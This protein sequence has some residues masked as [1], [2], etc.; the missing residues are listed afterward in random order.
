MF[1]SVIICTRN[2]CDKLANVL[3]SL[4][5]VNVPDGLLW[6]VLIVDN[7]STDS[8]VEVCKPFI[9][10][11]SGNYRYVFEGRKGKSVA[12]NRGITHARGDI[13]AFTDDDCIVARTWLAELAN[14]YA[15][16]PELAV[17]GGRV[18]LYNERDKPKSILTFG[19]RIDLS[20]N[21][22]RVFGPAIMGANMSF[23]KEVFN[24]VGEFD[25]LLGPGSKSGAIAEDLDYIYMAYRNGFKVVYFPNIVVYHDHGRQTD[26]E[27]D[28]LSY[29]Y[30][31][32]RG[33]FYC[34]HV[35]N[36]IE[37]VRRLYWD[38]RRHVEDFVSNF[39]AGQSTRN[40]R[41]AL[42]ALAVGAISRLGG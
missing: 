15:S 32:G 4:D 20:T 29:R 40:E 33:A 19:E 30:H 37:I 26:E 16:D 12:L 6:E 10:S 11:S 22:A 27:I 17:L 3:M 2:R 5:A 28:A 36:D 13:L 8:T 39:F 1:I 31:V 41:R 25:V 14:E 21:P 7:G 24:K 35:F 18:E 38:L 23:K 42:K 34:K 9:G